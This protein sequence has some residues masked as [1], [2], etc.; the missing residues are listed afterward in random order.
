M[1]RIAIG[2]HEITRVHAGEQMIFL[3]PV[4]SFFTRVRE[5]EKLWLAEPFFLEKRFDGLAPTVARDLG[6]VPAFAADHVYNARAIAQ[7]HGKRQPA[8]S[9]CREWHRAHLV[10]TGRSELRLQDLPKE[11]VT[12]LGFSTREA[13]ARHWDTEAQL[14][15][16]VS[17]KVRNN[18]RVYRFAFELVREPAVFAAKPP[19]QKRGR[20]PGPSRPVKVAP[21]PPHPP[22]PAPLPRPVVAAAPSIV[23]PIPRPVAPPPPSPPSTGPKYPLGEVFSTSKGDKGFV[24]ALKRERPR[25]HADQVDAAV[26]PRTKPDRIAQPLPSN[27]TCPRCGSRLAFG[28]EHHPRQEDAA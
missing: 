22:A 17:F 3:R 13:F 9:L 15:G 27:G 2:I 4:S 18:P 16:I 7:T 8:R 5:G 14:A 26:R 6:A 20:K 10:I 12:Q 25:M 21:P 19:P 11:D 28:C 24:A 23:A 1:R